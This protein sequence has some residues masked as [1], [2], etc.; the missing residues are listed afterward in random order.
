MIFKNN[1]RQIIMS[2][3]IVVIILTFVTISCVFREKNKNYNKTVESTIVSQVDKIYLEGI[4]EPDN[5]Q[6][7]YLDSTQGSIDK[8]NVKNGDYV[9]ED[10]ILYRYKNKDISEKISELEKEMEVVED[11]KDINGFEQASDDLKNNSVNKD[12]SAKDKIKVIQAQIDELRSKEYTEVKSPI[13]GTIYFNDNNSNNADVGDNYYI[14]I[15][16]NN[17]HIKA[18][19]SESYYN[20]INL[21]DNINISYANNLRGTGKIT[22]I[23]S[24]PSKDQD[25][26]ASTNK[27]SYYI[28]KVNLDNQEGVINGMHA[29]CLLNNWDSKIKINSESILKKDDKMIVYIIK[30]NKLEER[31]VDIDYQDDHICTINSGL[32]G[33]EKMVKNP[34]SDMS[35]GDVVK[36]E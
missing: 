5:I 6:Y 10:Y 4:V 34:T 21:N 16:S 13:E 22:Y 19:I 29:Q 23:D 2:I 11:T 9:K 18:F 15:Q 24:N 12:E 8:I 17:Y 32:D 1:S 31:E 30:D 36:V 33:G 26:T 28:V 14:K 7:I 3:L 27:L 35:S 20:R 25:N